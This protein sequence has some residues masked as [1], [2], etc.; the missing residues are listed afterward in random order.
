MLRRLL[1]DNVLLALQ[2]AASVLVPL[3]LIPHFVKTL[4]AAEYG[5]IAIAV[6]ALSYA[7]I[8]VQ[9]AFHLT[10][11]ADLAA[12]STAVGRKA[13]FL[14]IALA[15]IVLLAGILAVAASGLLI[16]PLAAPTSEG[17]RSA[18]W[19]LLLAL[20]V[21]AAFNAG[22]YLQC[23]GRLAALS[24]I[25]I[26]AATLTL[27]VGFTC[28]DGGDPDATMWAAGALGLGPLLTGVGTFVWAAATLP[29]ERATA[30]WQGAI[31]TLSSGSEIFLSQFVAAGYTLAGPIVVGVVVGERSAGLYS[32]VERIANALQ[33]A[34]GLTHVAAYPRLAALYRK[35]RTDYLRLVQMVLGV[36]TLAV[37]ALGV[38]LWLMVDAVSAFVFGEVSTE[39]RWLLA[40]AWLWLAVSVV[41]PPI[42]GYLTISGSRSEILSL[43][44]RVLLVS[45]P[46]GT[47]GA[48]VLA[49]PGW[50]AGLIA[51]QCLVLGRAI[52]AYARERSTLTTHH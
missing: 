11:P 42:T 7:S 39:S 44:W 31:R 38:L 1:A 2:Y 52:D 4:G 47:V 27:I 9:Y 35:A 19:W 17:T 24:A 46:A 21:G 12:R 20:P 5:R 8:V 18:H 25:S 14:D 23:T 22:W 36:N 49:G 41:G 6:A 51:G 28:V 34:L 3:A 45:L 13:L 50:L 10:G 48:V 43:T 33:T 15:R 30:S 32:A 37:G 26:A 40:L 16:A 29:R